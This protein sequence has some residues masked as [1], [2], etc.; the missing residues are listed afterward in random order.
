MTRKLREGHCLP[1]SQS[2]PVVESDLK[3]DRPALNHFYFSRKREH[4]LQG[5]WVCRSTQSGLQLSQPDLTLLQFSLQPEVLLRELRSK[6]STPHGN[7][8]GQRNSAVWKWLFVLLCCFVFLFLEHL[9]EARLFPCASQHPGDGH[10]TISPFQVGGRGRGMQ[11]GWVSQVT[12]LASTRVRIQIQVCR[13][14]H[15]CCP[16]HTIS[17]RFV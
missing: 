7:L 10:I 12:Q 3:P 15:A 8:R 16:Y 14:E 6:S 17:P 11:R 9:L 4:F 2:C 1:R 13:V 5:I